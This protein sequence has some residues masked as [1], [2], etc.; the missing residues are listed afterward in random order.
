MIR[1]ASRGM[2]NPS[3]VQGSP[4]MATSFNIA[5]ALTHAERTADEIIVAWLQRHLDVFTVQETMEL[6]LFVTR[7]GLREAIRLERVAD[8]DDWRQ[9]I[10]D[11]CQAK[12]REWFDGD[13]VRQ[14]L[15]GAAESGE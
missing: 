10:T 4:D 6:A 15:N 5:E 2:E 13:W 1:G 3:D 12:A 11:A 9:R 8:S 14:R 7:A